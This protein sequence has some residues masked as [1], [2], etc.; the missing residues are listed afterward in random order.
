M[1]ETLL[2]D[3]R[4]LTQLI[5]VGG[6]EGE[7]GR[8][9]KERLEAV[10]DKVEVSYTGTV[11]GYIK[12]D[13][14]GKKVVVTAHT[15]EIGFMVKNITE[16][17]FVLFEKAGDFSN[18]LLPARKVWIQTAEKRVPG[19]IGLRAAHIMTPEEAVKAQTS[20]Q[21]YIDVGASSREEVESYGIRL[22]DKIVLQSDFME[23]TNP[24]LIC[25]KALDDRTGCAILLNLM[26]SIDRAELAG[27]LVAVFSILEETTIAG[28]IAP[29]NQIQ[30]DYAIVLDTV[31]CGDVPDVDTAKELPVYM[32]RG[33]VL[34]IAQGDQP[35]LRYSC[36]NPKLRQ[37][38]YDVA[39]T[40]GMNLQELVISENVYVTEESVMHMAGTGVATATVSIPRRY[41]HTPIELLNINDA[42]KTAQL[43]QQFIKT[44]DKLDLKPF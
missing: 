17:G 27:E 24:D 15:D 5:G 12:G 33:P 38:F 20:K 26:E 22:G 36:I 40:L 6:S 3:I 4:S 37:R 44:H 42:V 29:V 1:K 7:V 41:S 34:I 18:K 19:V 25:T 28:T 43:L 13:L 8:F 14:P 23:M 21:S 32:N 10:C 30:P 31:P 9:V 39:D 2:K 11:M 16:D 35:N